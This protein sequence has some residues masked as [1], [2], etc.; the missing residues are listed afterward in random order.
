M[1]CYGR[2]GDIRFPDSPEFLR[3]HTAADGSK[4]TVAGAAKTPE[5]FPHFAEVVLTLRR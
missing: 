5:T 2:L 1:A 3:T 4:P